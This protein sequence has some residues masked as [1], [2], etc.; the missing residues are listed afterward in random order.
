[1]S[2][3][4]ILLR[5]VYRV[6]FPPGSSMR[7]GQESSDGRKECQREKALQGGKPGKQGSLNLPRG[8]AGIPGREALPEVGGTKAV[9]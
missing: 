1:M 9:A 6:V 2:T 3:F 4:N 8:V 7:A 5:L